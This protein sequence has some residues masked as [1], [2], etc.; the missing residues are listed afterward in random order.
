MA[1]IASEKKVHERIF[2]PVFAEC[3][4]HNAYQANIRQDLPSGKWIERWYGSCP[5]CAK[6]AISQRLLQQAS[7]PERY[8]N[9]RFDNYY[10]AHPSEECALGIARKYAESFDEQRRNGTCLIFSGEMGNGK[11]HLACSI[12]HHVLHQGYSALTIPMMSMIDKIRATWRKDSTT[13]QEE[14]IAALAQID[15]LIVDEVGSQRG[16]LDEQIT[17]FRILHE[18]YERKLPCLILSNLLPRRQHRGAGPSLDDYL[19]NRL[20]DRLREGGGKLVIFSNPNSH[21]TSV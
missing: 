14:I 12:A 10:P 18:R 8:R 17:L 4:K 11:N 3:P 13:T 1:A 2:S 20:M 19:G 7:I 6:E 16:T 9:S 21:R 15:L 5:R